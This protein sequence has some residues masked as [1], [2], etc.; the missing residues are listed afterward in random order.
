MKGYELRYLT[1][2]M[3]CR[4]E[5][6]LGLLSVLSAIGAVHRSGTHPPHALSG[7]SRQK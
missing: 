4:P 6:K 7:Q 1:L 3:E 2:E 5:E